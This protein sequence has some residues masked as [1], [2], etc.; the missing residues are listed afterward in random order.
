MYL[1]ISALQKGRNQGNPYIAQATLF[2]SNVNVPLL[3]NR[4]RRH[5]QHVYCRSGGDP[6]AQKP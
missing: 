4:K 2:H 1:Y 6:T 5:V 3:K